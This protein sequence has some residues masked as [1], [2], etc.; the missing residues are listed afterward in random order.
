MD[1]YFGGHMLWLLKND[2]LQRMNQFLLYVFQVVL[3][4]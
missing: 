3:I 2:I 4:N 1:N